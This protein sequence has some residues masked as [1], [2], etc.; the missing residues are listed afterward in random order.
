MNTRLLTSFCGAVFT[1][2]LLGTFSMFFF[3]D[4]VHYFMPMDKGIGFYATGGAMV[5][6]LLF[7][8]G[9]SITLC[10]IYHRQANGRRSN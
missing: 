2:L 3:G 9:I 8:Q 10:F 6:A 1:A 4:I 7:L 5:M